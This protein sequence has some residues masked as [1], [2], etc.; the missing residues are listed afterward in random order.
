MS[1]EIFTLVTGTFPLAVTVNET[2]SRFVLSIRAE[3]SFE[4]MILGSAGSRRTRGVPSDICNVVFPSEEEPVFA[5]TVEE[6]P[7]ED[8][9]NL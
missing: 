4:R 2:V 9:E 5:S 8:E 7:P 6:T 3:A 1:G